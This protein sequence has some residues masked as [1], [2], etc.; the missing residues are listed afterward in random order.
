MSSKDPLKILFGQALDHVSAQHYI[1]II[2]AADNLIEGYKQLKG[3][4]S[5]LLFYPASKWEKGAYRI[6]VNSRIEDIVGNNINGAFDHKIGTL[7]DAKEGLPIVIPFS[8]NQE[9]P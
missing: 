2:D 9:Q 3:E 7:K 1:V 5:E 4:D 6:V 8:I